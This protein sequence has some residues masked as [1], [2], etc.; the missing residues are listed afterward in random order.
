MKSALNLGTSRVD[1]STMSSIVEEVPDET[2]VFSVPL[3][4]AKWG[5]VASMAKCYA[6]L[7]CQM[8]HSS[9]KAKC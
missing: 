3:A 8:A 1:G 7:Y 4:T 5:Y 6:M 9:P 2:C